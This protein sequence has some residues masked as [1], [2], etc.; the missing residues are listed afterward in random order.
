MED[1]KLSSSPLTFASCY[2]SEVVAYGALIVLI[3]IPL[4]AIIV[5]GGVFGA[6]KVRGKKRNQ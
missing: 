4:V 3:A 5:V 1:G 2:G 6:K